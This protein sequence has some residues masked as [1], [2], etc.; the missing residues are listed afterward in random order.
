MWPCH[1]RCFHAGLPMLN[2]HSHHTNCIK[3]IAHIA[4]RLKIVRP[5]NWCAFTNPYA[6]FTNTSR[7]ISPSHAYIKHS[8][9][10]IRCCVQSGYV[11]QIHTNN[12]CNENERRRLA[13]SAY[14]SVVF[15]GG[16]RACLM[17]IDVVVRIQLTLLFEFVCVSMRALSVCVIPTQIACERICMLRIE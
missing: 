3:Q 17:V 12:Y 9:P 15:K 8:F 6:F 10:F 13:R 4:E 7:W 5:T 16:T 14:E 11:Q 2:T 1:I